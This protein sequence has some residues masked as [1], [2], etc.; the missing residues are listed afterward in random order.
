MILAAVIRWVLLASLGAVLLWHNWPSVR[1]AHV[2]DHQRAEFSL[3]YRQSR[4]ALDVFSKCRQS[5]AVVP[6]T[7]LQQDRIDLQTRFSALR[8]DVAKSPFNDQ[9]KVVDLEQQILAQDPKT[10]MVHDQI[11]CERLANLGP[12]SRET[13]DGSIDRIEAFLAKY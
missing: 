10:G 11:I 6:V 7:N 5:R 2:G 13:A 1:G 8:K 4:E 9:L 3:L 12:V